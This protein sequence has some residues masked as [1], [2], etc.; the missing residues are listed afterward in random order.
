MTSEQYQALLNELARVGG[1]ADP[2]PLLAHGRVKVGELNVLLEHE[3]NYDENL[4]QVRMLLGGFPPEQQDITKAL[5]EANY[6]SGY[7]G[8]CVFSLFPQ[9]DDVVVTMKL[10]LDSAM[11]AQ[12]LWQQLSDV[13]THG[14]R[15]WE[16][17][18]SAT[19]PVQNASPMNSLAAHI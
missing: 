4:L 2:T 8:E 14:A 6:T 12:E 19:P 10:R 1:L 7:G 13:A 9:S 17:I 18:V 3:P 15:M 11:S 5:L 16:A